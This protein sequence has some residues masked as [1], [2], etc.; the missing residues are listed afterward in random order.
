LSLSQ[1]PGVW[2]RHFPCGGDGS[3]GCSCLFLLQICCWCSGGVQTR[4]LLRPFCL[5][6]VVCT[7][8]FHLTKWEG[9][10]ARCI[11]WS[12]WDAHLSFEVD[13]GRHRSLL[14]AAL[15]GRSLSLLA[16]CVCVSS[17]THLCSKLLCYPNVLGLVSRLPCI[18]PLFYLSSCVKGPNNRVLSFLQPR[19]CKTVPSLSLA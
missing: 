8:L 4:K 17:V 13:G 19:D 2:G 10:T 14:L 5:H 11:D 3:P 1:N 16:L 9:G 15:T 18:T 12:V 6:P 7:P